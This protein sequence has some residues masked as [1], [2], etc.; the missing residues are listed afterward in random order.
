MKVAT[1][2]WS[3]GRDTLAD[4]IDVAN[5]E[6][7]IPKL[8]YHKKIPDYNHVDFVLGLDVFQ[9]V[10]SEILSFINKDQSH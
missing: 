4:P 2:M 5:L 10:F 1:V 7:N 8:V 9:Q 6:P 3:G